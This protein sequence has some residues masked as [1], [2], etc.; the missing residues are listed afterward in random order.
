[1]GFHA[2]DAEAGFAFGFVMPLGVA[3]MLT[4]TA[5]RAT[6]L[7]AGVGHVL[8]PTGNVAARVSRIAFF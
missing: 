7:R 1:M 8:P 5:A 3:F 6:A 2:L 4:L